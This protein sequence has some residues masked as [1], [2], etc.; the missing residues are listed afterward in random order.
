MDFLAA[1]SALTW[2]GVRLFGVRLGPTDWLDAVDLRMIFIKKSYTAIRL[3]KMVKIPTCCRRRFRCRWS[4][5]GLVSSGL[6]LEFLVK[7]MVLVDVDS[8]DGVV[9]VEGGFGGGGC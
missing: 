2:L 5:F 4:R 7:V 6:V 9:D 3:A 8:G 1:A